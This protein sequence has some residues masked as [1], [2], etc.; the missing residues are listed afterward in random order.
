MLPILVPA[1][2]AGSCCKDDNGFKTTDPEV[3]ISISQT[4][5]L[6]DETT[7]FSEEEISFHIRALDD[8][9]EEEIAELI[10]AFKIYSPDAA[11]W[12]TSSGE[13][14]SAITDW[15]TADVSYHDVTGEGVDVIG[16]HA[17]RDDRNLTLISEPTAF[18][19]DVLIITVGPIDASYE[20]QQICI[21]QDDFPPDVSW[22]WA[23]APGSAEAI[24]ESG[25]PVWTEELC[26][27]I[28]PPRPPHQVSI[29]NLDEIR[30]A[31]GIKAG[32]T[33]TFD[34]RLFNDTEKMFESMSIGF[35]I[36][37]KDNSH[38]TWTMTEGAAYPALEAIFDEV[39]YKPLE[40]PGTEFGLNGYGADTIG[41][42]PWGTDDHT[43]LVPGYDEVS[44]WIRIG[45]ID[46]DF[47][48]EEICIDSSWFRPTNPWL[49]DA[50]GTDAALNIAPSWYEEPQCFEII[51]P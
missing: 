16:Y 44:Y 51:S 6:L 26:L 33:F 50:D 4:D 41:F 8:V 29:N 1:I 47:I 22:Y 21:D 31:G 36:Y 17:Y 23:T 2:M 25:E 7:V 24:S 46:E 28:G 14:T 27:T 32:E 12:N 20:G 15:L 19:D 40:A 35:Q 13:A 9:Y 38:V 39:N 5:G 45:P 34:I 43:G 11:Q 3:F 18:S 49:W 37:P 10:L 30:E 48:G 42:V